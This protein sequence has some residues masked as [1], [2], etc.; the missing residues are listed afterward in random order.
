VYVA[1]WVPNLFPPITRNLPVWESHF[2][3]LVPTWSIME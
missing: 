2:S 3:A 1:S